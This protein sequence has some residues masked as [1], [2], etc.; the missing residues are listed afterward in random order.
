M[1]AIVVA[2]G[3]MLLSAAGLISILP[4]SAPQLAALAPDST[5]AQPL[6]SAQLAAAPAAID[7]VTMVASIQGKAIFE[8]NCAQCHAIN[9]VVVGPALKDVHTRRSIAWLVPWVRNSS[10]MVASGD[11]YAV[12]IFNQY[13]KQ[14][15]PSFQLSEAEIK[16]IMA[17]IEVES[18]L[19]AY[20]NTTG[21]L[22]YPR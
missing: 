20:N 7:S 10:K 3:S 21:P 8:N 1:L 17:Y 11:E 4:P 14:Q 18:T 15:M 19:T 16:S 6:D 22:P 13:Q 12:K 5:Q 9:E 2:M